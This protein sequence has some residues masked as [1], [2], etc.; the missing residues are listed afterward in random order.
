[1]S[2]ICTVLG[3]ILKSELHDKASLIATATASLTILINSGK[4]SI[5]ISNKILITLHLTGPA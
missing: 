4:N 1:M 2:I 5:K 3:G